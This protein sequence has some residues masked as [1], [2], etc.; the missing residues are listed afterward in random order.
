MDGIDIF[1]I[2]ASQMSKARTARIDVKLT[3]LRAAIDAARKAVTTAES[4]LQPAQQSARD[5]ETELAEMI[6][7]VGE[8]LSACGLG[9]NAAMAAKA[10]ESAERE[11][12]FRVR[13]SEPAKIAAGNLDQAQNDLK[14]V[15]RLIQSAKETLAARCSELEG[16][17]NKH[18]EI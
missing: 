18:T 6:S 3:E 15:R 13:N 1:A 4:E 7:T 5:A 10:P 14:S 16:F 12:S 17:I 9:L 11:F 2:N 8:H